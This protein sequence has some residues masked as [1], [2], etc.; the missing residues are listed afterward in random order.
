MTELQEKER[1]LSAAIV[2][3]PF[4]NEVA[5]PE[6]PDARSKLKHALVEASDG[7]EQEA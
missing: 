1:S 2:T 4:W 5:A 6:R 3:H 7:G